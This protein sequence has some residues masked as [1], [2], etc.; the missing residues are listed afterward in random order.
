MKL[1]RRQGPF[2][3]A[4]SREGS[5]RSVDITH[6]WAGMSFSHWRVSKSWGN[7]EPGEA[8]ERVYNDGGIRHCQLL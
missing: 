6:D 1:F 4:V 8:N 3:F 5:Y 2:Y 7:R